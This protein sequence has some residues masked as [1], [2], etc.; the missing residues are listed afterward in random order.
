MVD[1]KLSPSQAWALH[2][3]GRVTLIDLRGADN[4]YPAIQIPGARVIPLED[5]PGELVTIDRERPVVFV[6]VTGR[7]AS[8]ATKALRSVG[9]AASAV[10]G[11]IRAW[12]REGLPTETAAANA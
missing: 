7:K 3:G 10:E 5:L 9:M 12:V 1:G 11:G 2:L 4:P 8:G 6:S